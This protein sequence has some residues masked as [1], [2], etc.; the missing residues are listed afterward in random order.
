MQA[1]PGDAPRAP[2]T[3]YGSVE[4]H[5]WAR[6]AAEL[7]GLGDRAFRRVPVDAEYRIDVRALREMI[8]AD[9]AAGLAPFCV[10]GTA[11]TVNTGAT[12]DL[13]ALADVC[14]DEGLWFHVDGAFGALAHLSE[15]LRPIVAGMERADSLGF[16]LHKWGSLPIECACVLVRDPALH[17]AAFAASASYL[18]TMERGLARGGLPFADRGLDL[19]RGFK[20]LKAWMSLRADGV[21]KLARLIEQ[22][23]AQ[24]RHLV[25]RIAAHAELELLAPAPLNIACFRYAPAGM[26]EAERDALNVELLLRLQERGIAVPSS[27]VLGGRFALR[28]ANVNHRTR[29]ADLDALVDAVL[30]IGAELAR[31]A[32][33]EVV[34]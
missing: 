16:D 17:H 9:R 8:C 31:P 34:A 26:P 29:R 33:V 23:V 25:A 32:A 19:T 1:W 15:E 6:K 10:V 18:A 7:L 20:A 5:G 12:D 13:T 4:T 11:G 14:R 30:A 28:V 2:M 27:T 21:D 24:T 22:N 3:F